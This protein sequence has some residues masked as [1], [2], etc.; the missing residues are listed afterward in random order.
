MQDKGDV[1]AVVN[2]E[3]HLPILVVNPCKTAFHG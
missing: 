2:G 3:P 1:M